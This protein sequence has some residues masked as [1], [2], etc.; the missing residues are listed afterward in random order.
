MKGKEERERQRNVHVQAL[1]PLQVVDLDAGLLCLSQQQQIV[2]LKAANS[3]SVARSIQ[4]TERGRK[5]AT[6]SVLNNA[7]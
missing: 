4:I 6:F 2:L 3:M 1:E 7:A 5:A